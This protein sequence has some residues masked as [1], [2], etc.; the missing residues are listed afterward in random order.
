MGTAL[1][2]VFLRAI[3]LSRYLCQ[4]T[5]VYHVVWP[6]AGS[7]PPTRSPFLVFLCLVRS[8]IVLSRIVLHDSLSQSEAR[9]GRLLILRLRQLIHA[10]REYPSLCTATTP[11][12]IRGYTPLRYPSREYPTSPASWPIFTRLAFIVSALSLVFSS[13]LLK[14]TRS[15]QSL[16][17]C[18]RTFRALSVDPST[19]P[20]LPCSVIRSTVEL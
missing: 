17:P 9:F 4:E 14:S 12:S 3:Y 1:Q 15:T 19:C 16:K 7:T 6:S 18:C 20:A 8:D 2:R 13:S 11:S 10:T 5:A